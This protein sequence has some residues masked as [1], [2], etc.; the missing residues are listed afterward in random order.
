MLKSANTPGIHNYSFTD[1]DIVDLGTEIVYYRLK[2]RDAN[3]RY[4]YSNSYYV[5]IIADNT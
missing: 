3:N 4:T 5:S 1:P 2:Q